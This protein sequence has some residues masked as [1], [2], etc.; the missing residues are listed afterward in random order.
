ML[1]LT[2]KLGEAVAIGEEIK[3][4][5]LQVKGKQVRLGVKAGPT[6]SVHREEVYQKISKENWEATR[7][8]SDGLD[9]LKDVF[10]DRDKLLFDKK[11]KPKLK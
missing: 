7:V 10:S 5:V 9:H 3:V 4:V 6:T 2:R 1:V 8:R 11:L